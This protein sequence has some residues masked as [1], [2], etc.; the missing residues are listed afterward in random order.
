MS[1]TLALDLSLNSTGWAVGM[2]GKP[3]MTTGV[4]RPDLKTDIQHWRYISKSL[5]ELAKHYDAGNIAFLEWG[6]S[7]NPQAAKANFGL[8]AA[9]MLAFDEI[10]LEAQGYWES[11]CRKVLGI[12]ISPKLTAAEAEDWERRRKKNPKAPKKRDMKVRVVEVLAA[13]GLIF[14]THDEADAAVLLMTVLQAKPA[15]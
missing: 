9:I 7:P 8:R 11:S 4:L 3:P 13:M 1:R 10:G 14:D 15:L 6:S 2:A 12:N 5:V